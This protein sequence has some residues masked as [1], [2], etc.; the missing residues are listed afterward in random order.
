VSVKQLV[1]AVTDVAK[2]RVNTK[3]VRGPVGVQS[4]NF[5]NEKIYATGWRPQF[6]LRDGI[7]RTYPWIE[8][9]VMAAK[10]HGRAPEAKA[11]SS[12]GMARAL[13]EA[14]AG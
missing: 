2:K 14:K 7:Q 3:Y 11:P 8:E 6:S 9:Q 5:S 12:I 10:R 13:P 1:D 4:R